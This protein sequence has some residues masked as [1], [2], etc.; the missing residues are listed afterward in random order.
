[1]KLQSMMLLAFLFYTGELRA[2]GPQV[3]T[4]LGEESSEVHW[5]LKVSPIFEVGSY[6]LFDLGGSLGVGYHLG[7]GWTPMLNFRYVNQADWESLRITGGIN[8]SFTPMDFKNSFYTQLNLG[9]QNDFIH[10][11]GN[12]YVRRAFVFDFALGKRFQIFKNLSY[13]PEISFYGGFNNLN[14][15]YLGE[16]RIM[17]LQVSFSF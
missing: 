15:I 7:N 5:L 12:E 2:E 16:V 10:V 14:E 9:I 11:F 4:N 1:M 17:P 6:S 3:N 8:Y 13:S